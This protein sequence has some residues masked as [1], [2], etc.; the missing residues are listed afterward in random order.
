MDFQDKIV[1]ISG[2]SRGIG[3]ALVED[4]LHRNVQK[5]Y[6][7][8]RDTTTIQSLNDPRVV[9]IALDITDDNQIKNAASIAHDTNVLIN[10]AGALNFV[11]AL[12]GPLGDIR[13]DMEVN[14]FGTLNMMRHFLPILQKRKD[15]VLANVVSV[16]A[17][18]NFLFHGGYCASK[19]A[20]FSITQGAMIEMASKGIKV[21]SIN[22]G[23]IDTDMGKN[24][25][26]EKTSPKKTAKAI[27]DG[28]EAEELYISP[29][30]I[31]AE[32]FKNWTQNF[33]S[34]EQVAADFM[35][36]LSQP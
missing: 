24:L 9:P 18:V 10:N 13:H 20:L 33:R 11:N 32:M 34:L 30:P 14:Y 29:D 26:I 7:A 16:A 6:A 21:H 12:T 8:A 31:G 25:D 28:I 4:L 2:T 3:K 17:F 27:L 35:K 19:A 1:F 22:P 5:I 15:S 36:G 23:P